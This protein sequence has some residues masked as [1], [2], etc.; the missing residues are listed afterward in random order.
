LSLIKAQRIQKEKGNDYKIIVFTKAL[1]RYMDAGRKALG[2]TNDFY[3]YWDWKNRRHCPSAD[4]II[5]DEI[6]DFTKEEI[7]EF[8]HATRKNFFFFGDIA[9]SIYEDLKDTFP[10]N[11]IRRLFDEDHEPKEFSLYSN[12]RLPIPVA[13]ITEQYVYVQQDKNGNVIQIGRGN[14]YDENIYKSTENEIPRFI[15]Y[16]SLNEQ[17]KAIANIKNRQQLSD[18]GILLP[19]NE[20]VKQVSMLL[21][22]L[23][24]DHE[25]KYEDKENRID[26]LDF[27]TINPKVMTYHSAKGLQFDTVF[28]P[29]ILDLSSIP[30]RHISEQKALYVAMTRTCRLLYVMYSGS[31]PHPLCDVPPI[32]YKTTE[33][34]T[35]EDI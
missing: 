2:L 13:R 26:T 17:V 1:C 15:R 16:N 3:Y 34:D 29:N 21:N 11:K 31:L 28:L 6:Q 19:H 20:N 35:I 22:S 9:Q 27:T 32:L 24:V 12:Y 7:L 8:I 10:V 18:V 25:L 5:V 30:K 4:Y 23:G 33:T 14:S